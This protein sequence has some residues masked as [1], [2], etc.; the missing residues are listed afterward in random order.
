MGGVGQLSVSSIGTNELQH[1]LAIVWIVHWVI[2]QFP[3]SER[4]NCNACIANHASDIPDFFQFPLSERTNCNAST[5]KPNAN[6]N[7]FQFPLSE[8]TNC[9]KCCAI[10]LR[11]MRRSFSFLY[12]NERTATHGCVQVIERDLRLSVSSIGTNEL[13]QFFGGMF[14]AIQHFQFP[15]SERTNCNQ[16]EP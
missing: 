13:Q 2:F 8:R 11:L 15:L 5:L 7:C 10:P 6:F 12:R 16:K 9:N 1:E 3:L 14:T 4:T